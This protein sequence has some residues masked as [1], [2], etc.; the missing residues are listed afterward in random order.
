MV[1]FGAFFD[2][3]DHKIKI[4]KTVKNYIELKALA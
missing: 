2:N 4:N 1:V 3:T